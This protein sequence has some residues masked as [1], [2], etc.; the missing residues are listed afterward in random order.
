MVKL[1]L[2]MLIS[3]NKPR[4]NKSKLHTIKHSGH[5]NAKNISLFSIDDDK[6]YPLRV[7]K[8]GKFFEVVQLCFKKYSSTE[9]V[10]FLRENQDV[11]ILWDHVKFQA[12]F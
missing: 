12:S 4:K 7:A 1:L 10:E 5:I 2:R 3:D 11:R 6:F 9:V 8:V